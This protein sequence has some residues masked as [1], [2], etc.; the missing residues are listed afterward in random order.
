MG[1]FRTGWAPRSP[2]QLVAESFADA[3]F[4]SAVAVVHQ[5]ADFDYTVPLGEDARPLGKDAFKPHLRAMR[6]FIDRGQ[7][8]RVVVVGDSDEN[9]GAA[10][11]AIRRAFADAGGYPS[12][13]G[14]GQLAYAKGA[15]LGA[16]GIVVPREGAGALETLLLQA[17]I[18]THVP[19][20]C[21]DRWVECV[22]F[23]E[24]PRGA[25]DKFR[26]RSLIAA[27]VTGAP[28]IHL[29]QIWSRSDCP[30]DPGD[31]V[32]AWI[33][34]FLLLAFGRKQP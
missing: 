15:D 32:F 28:D 17:A 8:R 13:A 12:L 4:V 11:T 6:A 20:A 1:T 3:A 30:F 23:P 25:Y 9:H 21:V 18:R 10:F 24:R 5:V 16:G 27:T 7:V 19:T 29:S 26:L 14:P 2:N 34:N 31:P 22:N 33:G